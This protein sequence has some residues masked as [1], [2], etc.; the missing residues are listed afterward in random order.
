MTSATAPSP[1]TGARLLGMVT[2]T[3]NTLIP[4][5]T[6]N[7][8]P[9]NFGCDFDWSLTSYATPPSLKKIRQLQSVQIQYANGAFDLGS[10]RHDAPRRFRIAARGLQ[11]GCKLILGVDPSA[12]PTPTSPATLATRS[13]EI[14]LYTTGMNINGLPVWESAIE[15]D[16]H[17]Y[18]VL[19]AGGRFAPGVATILD[20]SLTNE[21]STAQ[22]L[23][24]PTAW[25]LHH[26][27]LQIPGGAVQSFGWLPL[28]LEP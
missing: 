15:L 3:A 5:F 10:F 20:A 21:R 7:W 1:I 27:A 4:S 28:R 19:L 24:A 16:L 23:F 6:Q 12:T 8:V 22:A 14:P 25:N 13:L 17:E 2:N 18:L 9:T 11:P 26:V